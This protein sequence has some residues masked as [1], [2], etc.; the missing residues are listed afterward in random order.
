MSEQQSLAEERSAVASEVFGGDVEHVPPAADSEPITKT[1]DAA[2][3][4][5]APEAKEPDPW[6]GVPEVVKNS[7]EATT[8]QL[9]EF[10][11]Q[12]GTFS[13][14]FNEHK[15]DYGRIAA[16]LQRIEAG[17][18][19]AKTA[20]NAPTQKQI[21]E[22]SQSL[23][24][25]NELKAEFS[26]W[27]EGIDERINERI[28]ASS[29]E[30]AKQLPDVSGIEKNLETKLS[31]YLAEVTKASTEE[32]RQLAQLDFRHPDWEDKINSKEFLRVAF[33][34]GPSE[35]EIARYFSLK[36]SAPLEAQTYFRDFARTH[37][38]WW[39]EKGALID[40][41]KAA[42]ATKLLD[43]FNDQLKA[44]AKSKSIAEE[45]NKRLEQSQTAP[46][47]RLPAVKSEADMSDEEL[48]ASLAKEVW[49]S[50]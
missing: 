50:A 46:G 12:F 5:A 17:K 24:K 8:R 14:V 47:R 30:F 43:I 38:K 15:A 3:V 29:A 4:E 22:A 1:D 42:D 39:G 20:D 40:S 6:D 18:A 36:Q 32:T 41:D 48:R 13:K 25:W 9:A 49:D 31:Q 37:P 35:Q 21:V 34:D 16:S 7:H 27:S 11:K 19:A 44:G 45:R 26:D 28:A 23:E 10:S 33:A 2:V